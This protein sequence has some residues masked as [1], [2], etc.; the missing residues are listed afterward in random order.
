MNILQ[1]FTIMKFREKLP[2]HFRIAAQP[3]T[4]FHSR[5]PPPPPPL[6]LCG[7]KSLQF[8]FCGKLIVIERPRVWDYIRHFYSEPVGST[9]WILLQ[10]I[11][12][13]RDAVG[14]LNFQY[15]CNPSLKV[16]MLSSHHLYT[17][18][19]TVYIRNCC[20]PFLILQGCC[21]YA[22]IYC[23]LS[24][25][26]KSIFDNRDAANAPFFEIVEIHF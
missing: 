19:C 18:Q 11:L 20:S 14:T 22:Y 25:L 6:S 26:L 1:A 13:T 15:C 12:D 5:C 23:I 10:S 3:R 4:A 21:L 8:V 9:Q 24:E 16:G 2:K 17:V 7:N